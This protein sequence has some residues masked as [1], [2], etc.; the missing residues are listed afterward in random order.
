[1]R[2]IIKAAIRIIIIIMILR[3]VYSLVQN[4]SYISIYHGRLGYE[5]LLYPL[6]IIDN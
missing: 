3:L 2:A 5:D 1:M 4:I 6:L